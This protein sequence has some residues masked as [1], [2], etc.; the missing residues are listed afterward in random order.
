MNLVLRKERVIVMLGKFKGIIYATLGASFF[1]LSSIIAGILFERCNLNPE[2]L[3][4]VRMFVSGFILLGALIVCK[5]DV[6][7]IWKSRTSAL[8][9]IIFGIFG[10]LLAQ[11]SFV[12]SIYYGNPAIATVLQSLG[13]SIIIIFLAIRNNSLPRRIDIIAII[14][15]LLGIFLLVTNG[16]LGELSF[17]TLAVIWGICS[18]FGVCTYTLIPYSLIKEHSPILVAA[19][20]LLIGGV[21]SNIF[22]LMTDIPENF[23]GVDIM[24]VIIII[25]VGTLLAYSFYISSLNYAEPHVVGMLSMIEPVVAILISILF[26]NVSFQK[27]QSLGIVLVFTALILINFKGKK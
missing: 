5:K 6:M 27:F 22:G 25:V 8:T 12:L 14:L 23:T 20:G 21:I 11:T 26:L 18:A 15:S 13:P 24:L 17:S 2:W 4:T 9:I 19:W 3:V 1:G 7:G 16:N 10:V